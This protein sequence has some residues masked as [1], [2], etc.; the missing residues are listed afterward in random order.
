MN[1]GIFYDQL[2]KFH[3]HQY[4]FMHLSCILGFHHEFCK[5]IQDFSRKLKNL[6]A[7]MK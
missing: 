1:M 7:V 6:V 5:I 2:T 4:L 3:C